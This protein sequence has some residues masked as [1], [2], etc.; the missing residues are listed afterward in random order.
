MAA[1]A[2]AAK[3]KTKTKT[4]TGTTRD[5]TLQCVQETLAGKK[6]FHRTFKR[7]ARHK[8]DFM[9]IRCDIR[10]SLHLLQLLYSYINAF[11]FDFIIVIIF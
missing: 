1:A 10:L 2:A 11:Y 4:G 5:A 9:A 6:Y 3:I 8:I 7:D